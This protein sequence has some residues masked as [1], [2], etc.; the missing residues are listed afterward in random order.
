MEE[1]IKVSQLMTKNVVVANLQNKLSQV[2]QFY[3]DTNIQ[4]LPVTFDN[5][6]LGIVS[7]KDV[8]KY[9]STELKSGNPV[10]LSE[11]DAKFKLEDIMTKSPVYVH[12]DDLVEKAIELLSEGKFQ[13]LPVVEEGKIVGIV[14]NKDIVRLE[15]VL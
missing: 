13:A 9:L 6:L 5:V 8:L 10:S 7:I 15:N 4:H 2:L 1:K 12:P 3:T 14:T 11:L